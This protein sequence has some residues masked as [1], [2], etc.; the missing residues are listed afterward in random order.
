MPGVGA[1][2]PDVAVH[3][4]QPPAI[5]YPQAG[6]RDGLFTILALGSFALGMVAIIVDVAGGNRRVK[7]EGGRG[8]GS[9]GILPLRFAG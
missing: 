1:P 9:T 2:F 8:T 7:V 6:H 4:K 5:G 3:I